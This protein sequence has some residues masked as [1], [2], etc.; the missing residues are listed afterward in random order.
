M[1]TY[2]ISHPNKFLLRKRYNALSDSIA[3]RIATKITRRPRKVYRIEQHRIKP[4]ESVLLV[5]GEIP[6]YADQLI[7]I[8]RIND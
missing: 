4:I 7:L 6:I 1:A 2:Q 3:M 8:G 5:P